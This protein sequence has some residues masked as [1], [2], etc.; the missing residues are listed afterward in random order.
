L[1]FEVFLVDGAA[2]VGVSSTYVSGRQNITSRNTILLSDALASA[3]VYG[4]TAPAPNPGDPLF[5]HLRLNLAG[6]DAA[7][8]GFFRLVAMSIRSAASARLYTG[9]VDARTDVR[10]LLGKVVIV[11]DRNCAAG[12]TSEPQLRQL[13]NIESGGSVLRSYTYGALLD[14]YTTPPEVDADAKSTTATML[15]MV[16]PD[17]VDATGSNP[18]FAAF[19]RDYG[20]QFVPMRYYVRDARL[21]AYE[22]FF[23]NFNSGMVRFAE[24]VPF[25]RGSGV[26]YE[27]E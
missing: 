20:V 4:F 23:A 1:D 3:A 9:A 10:D 27:T 22:A 7:Q 25:I 16:V 19:V 18:D 5:L 6:T 14:Q 26:E 17:A 8:T 15:R 11:L 13:V 24:C 21:A 2:R 12:Y